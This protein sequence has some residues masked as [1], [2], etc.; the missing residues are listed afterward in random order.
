MVLFSLSN[1]KILVKVH[2]SHFFLILGKHAKEAKIMLPDLIW[3]ETSGMLAN[4][5]AKSGVRKGKLSKKYSLC[6]DRQ[7]PCMLRPSHPQKHHVF[8]IPT[9]PNLLPGGWLIGR[10]ALEVCHQCLV[11]PDLADRYSNTYFL[12]VLRLSPSSNLYLWLGGILFNYYGWYT[13]KLE[14]TGVKR[15]YKKPLKNLTAFN[16]YTIWGNYSAVVRMFWF[17]FVS[18]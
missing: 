12:T 6:P 14:S 3:K 13:F 15:T 8:E 17:G 1:L 16:I 2:H 18:L 5:V 10:L 9:I 4:I 7:K 11:T